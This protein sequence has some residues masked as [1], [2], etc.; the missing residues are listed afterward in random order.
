M[1]W[2]SDQAVRLTLWVVGLTN[3]SHGLT[4]CSHGLTICSGCFGLHVG[5]GWLTL[6]AEAN[7][8]CRCNHHQLPAGRTRQNAGTGHVHVASV[9]SPL[10][11]DRTRE[12]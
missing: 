10:Y 3:C 4:N 8:S 7:Q 1:G 12:L 5:C 11:V 2:V 9:S 6:W